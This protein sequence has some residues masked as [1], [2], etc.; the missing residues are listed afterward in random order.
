VEYETNG[1]IS[2]N[3]RVPSAPNIME[4]LIFGYSD[5]LRYTILFIWSIQIQSYICVDLK[6]KPGERVIHNLSLF[7]TKYIYFLVI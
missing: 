7:S 3:V 4:F 6:I 5:P 2:L 1:Q